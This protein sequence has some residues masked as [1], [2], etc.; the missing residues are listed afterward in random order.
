[1]IRISSLVASMAAATALT[2]GLTGGATAATQTAASAQGSKCTTVTSSDGAGQV[3]VCWSWTKSASGNSYYGSFHGKFY[4][5]ATDGKW[6]ILQAKWSGSG[7]T[8]I[9]TAAN[10]ESFAGDYSGLNGLNFRACVT[11]GHCGSAAW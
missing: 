7:W 11:G 10:G 2:V 9:R 5:R 1:M 4:D 6:V 3:Y 8:P